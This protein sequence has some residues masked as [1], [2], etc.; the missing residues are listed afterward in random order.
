MSR[1]EGRR[2]VIT[3]GGRG[4][5]R[6]IALAYAAE[7]ARCVITAR[8]ADELAA[9]AAEAPNGTVIPIECDVTSDE[10]VAAMSV[11]A[12]EALGEVDIVVNNA[13]IHA[14]GGFMDIDPDTYTRLFDV[15]VVGIVRVSQAFL[16]GMIERG[17]GRIVNMASTAGLFESPGQAPYNAS[18]HGAVG[19]TRCMALEMAPMGVT[20]NAICP[21][22]VDT[23]MIDGF[24][25]LVGAER[26]ELRDRL[27]AR[28]P[29][30]RMLQPEEIAGLAVHIASDIAGGM[31]G[32]T[33]V[34]SNGMRMA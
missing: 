18:K 6:A 26:D 11:A 4:I 2:A 25:T 28:T 31:T 15:N 29:M 27:A 33:M 24:A 21:G 17:F 22:F 20:V 10:S 14:S 8:S 19:L 7:G 3:G 1:L 16:P 9:V 12:N 5:G 34:V 32:Q 30:G 23:P 13:G